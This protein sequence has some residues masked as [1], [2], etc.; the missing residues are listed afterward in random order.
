MNAIVPLNITAIRV[1]T[2]DVNSV[3]SNLKGRTAL[4]DQMPYG[5]SARQA[6][7]GTAIVQP[8]DSTSGPA[9]PLGA[10]VHVHWELPRYF[11]QGVQQPNGS[12]VVFPQAP[13]RW[14]VIRYLSLWQPAT[15]DYG[16]VVPKA[17]IIESDYVQATQTPDSYGVIRPCVSV[18]LPSNPSLGQQPYMY[19]GRVLNYED[20]NPS[21]ETPSE[22]L[23]CFTGQDGS[24]LYLT[25]VGVA[26]PGFCNYYPECP[27]V[28]GFWDH[29]KDDSTI[30]NAIQSDAALQFKVTY[31][32]VGWI[33]PGAADPMAAVAQQV[34]SQYNAY[35]AE[36]AKQQVPVAQSPTD[37]FLSYSQSNLRWSFQPSAVSYTL[38]SDQT[39]A[40]LDV[41]SATICAGQ[42]QEIVWNMLSATSTAFLANPAS[43]Q[44]PAIWNDT[45]EAAV[46]NS[47]AEALSAILK[48]DLN[49]TNN[50]PNILTNFEYLLDALQLGLLHDL[51]SQPSKTTYLDESIHAR[52]FSQESGGW[53]WIIE[54]PS[55]NA[56]SAPDP[57]NEITLPLSMAE[58][59]ALL[60]SAQKAYD[61][62]RAALGEMRKQL[63]M[64][65]YRYINMYAGGINDP[66]VSL[67]TLSAFLVSGSTGE[68]NEV[69]AAG[70]AAGMLTYQVDPVSGEVTG[71]AAPQGSGALANAVYNQFQVV[72][73]QIPPS[74]GWVLRAVPAP[75]FYSP[76]DPVLLVEG[77]RIEPSNRDGSSRYLPVRVSAELLSSIAI[78][79]GGSVLQVAASSI[80]GLPVASAVTP[81]AADVQTL[82]GEAYLLT[83]S[84][85]SSV[86]A[87][88]AAQGGANNPAVENPAGFAACLVQAQGGL[89]PLE[90]APTGGL[91]AAVH[92]PSAVPAANS[93]IAVTAPIALTFTFTNSASNGW[94]PCPIAWNGQTS[95]PAFSSTR[96]DPFLPVYF[97]WQVRFHPL[98]WGSGTNY[99]S[100]NLSKYFELTADAVD[101]TY[102]VTG[103][104][105]PPFVASN[106]VDYTGSVVLSAKAAFN[107]TAQV[108]RYCSQYPSDPADPSLEQIKALYETRNFLAQS[109]SGFSQGLTLRAFLP[110]IPVED[111]SA[112]Q[113]RDTVTAALRAAAAVAPGDNWYDFGFNTV[114][115]IATGLLAQNNFGPLRAGFLEVRSLQIVDVFG[116]IMQLA[117]SPASP[118]G[119]FLATAAMTVQ[120]APGDTTDQNYIFLPPRIT[121]PSRLWFRWLSATFNSAV[122]GI[123]SDF[124]EMN[125]H[126]ATSPVCGWVVPNHLDNSLFFYD[127]T[128]VPIGSFGIEHGANVYR[129]RAG[130]LANPT[131]SLAADIGPQGQP[132]VNPSVASFMW[133]VSQ[134]SGGFLADLLTT[135]ENTDSCIQPANF[136]AN[137]GLAVFIGRP[138]AIA[139]TVLSM[140][141]SGGVLPLSQADTTPSDAFPQD[142]NN[143]RTTYSARQ[144]F[145]SANLAAVQFPVR[146]GNLADISDGLVGFLIEGSAPNP[147]STFYSPAAPSSGQNGV[148]QPAPDTIQLT[149]NAPPMTLTMLI[150][151]RASV[152]ATTGVLPVSELSI[153]PDQYSG[154]MSS[155][156]VTFF[157]TP[158]LSESSGLIVPV[159]AEQGYVWNWITPGAPAPIPIA[160]NAAN[161]N[162]IFN[163]TPQSILEGWLALDPAPANPQS[164]A[165]TNGSR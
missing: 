141:T 123:S 151:P 49:N 91:F 21:T 93:S 34:T 35:V 67:N 87:A 118:D 37:F 90:G 153:P 73:S 31:Q 99:T 165:A 63:F 46:G 106:S 147:Y 64:D 5:A 114:A 96:V 122:P 71:L 27:S 95:L 3:T 36:C 101:Y 127:T 79:N 59:L 143:G 107:L 72:L 50:D 19:M 8:L 128:G 61:Q 150:D 142:V 41:P 7:T 120:P 75:G 39:L 132:T 111:L 80:T 42:F 38:N 6:S 157:T 119:S 48:R 144:Q 148:V 92:A 83:P 136:A 131:N 44:T 52:A 98:Q 70:T 162:A 110:A 56:G 69:I 112:L 125:T 23:P 57:S 109:I 104:A 161:G 76:T 60:N 124:V 134:G 24:P 158:V 16:P 54:V 130:N 20:W 138:L 86:T 149:L 133:Y 82:I 14:L 137:A 29:F 84:M 140:E 66:N 10:G 65:W 116:Q 18:P 113:P 58:E 47:P 85:Q 55:A 117:T 74:S 17:F 102:A 22:F 11:R 152:H 89:S 108:E 13:N 15:Q 88:L 163:Y 155:L 160:S 12:D 156:A 2:N 33:N 32:V 159:P 25:A 28:F 62:G 45:V 40:T 51:D 129:T 103:G 81:N 139:R 1:N 105:P 121:A 100:D 9:N 146:L 135:I 78:A 126:P 115:P 145:S 53:L 26:G 97:I 94:A 77:D 43:P 164:N 4:F 68:I 30:Y 154:A